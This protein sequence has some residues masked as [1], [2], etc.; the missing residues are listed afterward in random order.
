MIIIY[1]NDIHRQFNMPSNR[2]KLR[3]AQPCLAVSSCLTE[4][5]YLHIP[6]NAKYFLS[7]LNSFNA[8]AFFVQISIN[9]EIYFFDDSLMPIKHSSK[10]RQM[11]N[12]NISIITI[13]MYYMSLKMTNQLLS[14]PLM[15]DKYNRSKNTI[16]INTTTILNSYLQNLY[17]QKRLLRG[18]KQFLITHDRLCVASICT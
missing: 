13:L 4:L 6:C 11:M 9:A 18:Q 1:C 16:C 10:S 7:Q 5:N 8:F 14:R 17:N 3:C 12:K 2:F 15:D